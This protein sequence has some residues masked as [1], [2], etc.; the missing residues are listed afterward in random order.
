[1]AE[2]DGQLAEKDGQLAEK[3]GQ[4]AEKDGQLKASIKLL[5]KM[6]QSKEMIAKSLGL[7]ID[8]V[9]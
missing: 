1:L 4:L 6:G 8:E 3:D 7:N 2:K 5:L 9:E